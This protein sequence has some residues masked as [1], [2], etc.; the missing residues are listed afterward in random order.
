MK[1]Q[2][3]LINSI[4]IILSLIFVSCSEEDITEP[5]EESLLLSSSFENNGKFSAEGWTLPIGSDSSFDVP[6]G[7]GKYSLIL[8]AS[9][10]PELYAQIKVPV[11]TKYNKFKFTFWSKSTSVTNNIYGKAILSLIRNGSSI[12]SL[13]VSVDDIIWKSYSFQDTFTVTA[14]DSF[15]VQLTGGISQLFSG[16]SYFD[17]CKL[18]GVD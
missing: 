17:L 14:G 11:K 9:N 3:S 1:K 6:S 12:R 16:K 7:G 15:L 8:E 2:L 4:L 5:T 18:Y 10:P 13:S